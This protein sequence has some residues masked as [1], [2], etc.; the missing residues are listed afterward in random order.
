MGGVRRYL[1]NI[2]DALV[3]GEIACGI[4]YSTRRCDQ[5]FWPLLERFRASAWQLFEVPMVRAIHPGRDARNLWQIRHAVQS[6]QPHVV[7]C[8]SSKAGALGRL[9]TRICVSPRPVTIYSPHAT[10]IRVSPGVKTVE[11]CLAK[12]TDWFVAVS[13]SEAKELETELRVPA[14][15]VR[16]VWPVIDVDYF[17][18]TD[19]ADARRRIRVA[20]DSL[21]LVAMGRLCH[22]KD[23]LTFIKIA[24]TLARE[25][26]RLQ[27]IWV[28]DGELCAEMKRQIEKEGLL[29]TVRITGWQDDVRPYVAAADVVILPSRYESFGYATAEALAMGRPV[30]ATRV[31]GTVDLISDGEYG[32]LFDPGDWMGGAM[33]TRHL[34]RSPERAQSMGAAGCKFV[35]ESFAMN[36]MRKS[37]SNLYNQVTQIS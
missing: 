4:V 18:V 15:R 14:E 3:V 26:S 9:A 2:A 28:G 35:A 37:L 11:R 22:Q 36:R 30:V 31:T 12:L 21:L 19:K 34:L 20:E 8:H 7:H 27:A 29:E 17:S 5:Q 1:E 13:R 16:V 10:A 6:F 25:F 32:L 33:A 23:P 24:K